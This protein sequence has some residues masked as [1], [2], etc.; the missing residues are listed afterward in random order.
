MRKESE[1]AKSVR[2]IIVASDFDERVVFA[3]STLHNLLLV[4]YAFNFNFSHV[5]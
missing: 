1:L 3:A 4:K 2:S 5:T